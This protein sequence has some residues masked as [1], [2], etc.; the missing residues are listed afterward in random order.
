MDATM[1]DEG[2][3]L[4]P[5]S[6]RRTASTVD[7]G[8]GDPANNGGKAPIVLRVPM[9]DF[10][11]DTQHPLNPR[12]CYIG[13]RVTEH[14]QILGD[15]VM[16]G[17]YFVFD[18]DNQEVHVAQAANCGTE[19]LAIGEGRDAVPGVQGK[20]SLDN[21]NPTEA[22]VSFRPRDNTFYRTQ[23]FVRLASFPMPR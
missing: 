14:Q 19:I 21:P 8:F 7:F 22:P 13:L 16:R 12:L 3:F 15:S 17:G 18:W 1:D 4:A 20:C 5:C 6:L 2:F 10:I 11:L 23:L 9:S